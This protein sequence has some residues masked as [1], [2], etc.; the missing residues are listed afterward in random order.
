MFG[1]QTPY[2]SLGGSRQEKKQ[3]HW[4][5]WTFCLAFAQV[6][7]ALLKRFSS[8]LVLI[9]KETLFCVIHVT[10]LLLP[11]PNGTGLLSR[12]QGGKGYN[13]LAFN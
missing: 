13:W 12:K 4:S 6:K 11:V 10:N 2:I 3:D 5:T 1:R 8:E 9:W 7:D